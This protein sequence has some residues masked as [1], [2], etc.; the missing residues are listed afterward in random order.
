MA[1]IVAPILV[2]HVILS[3]VIVP[4]VPPLPA[5]IALEGDA[6]V[7]TL[8]PGEHFMFFRSDNAAGQISGPEPL[9]LPN[10]ASVHL[11]SAHSSYQ[12]TCRTSPSPAGLYVE[13][14]ANVHDIKGPLKK[15]FVTAK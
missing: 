12:L 13:A 11:T 5:R 14:R 3:H 2:R 10:G 8:S 6:I 15:Y 7:M 4:D 1:L 9:T